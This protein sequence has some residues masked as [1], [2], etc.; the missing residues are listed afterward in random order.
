MP[1][2]RRLIPILPDRPYSHPISSQITRSY[3]V[4]RDNFSRAYLG[5]V[6][7]LTIS[8]ADPVPDNLQAI[9]MTTINLNGDTALAD[10]PFVRENE[11]TLTCDI[12]PERPGFH[13]YRAQFSLDGGATWFR[14]TVEDAW[15]LVDPP[16]A[17]GLRLYVLVPTVS[18]TMADWKSD[19][20]RI[21]AMGFNAVH[22]LPITTLDTSESPYAARDLFDI[23]L[24]YLRHG[25]GQDG[26]S[27]LEDF[28]E[29]ARALD[30]RLCFD[31]VL[32]HI[33]V[34]STMARRAPDWIVPDKDQPDGLHRAGYESEK[35]WLPWNDLVQINYKH[36]SEMVRS[37]IWTYMIE[38]A[39]FWAKYANDTG[40]FVRFDNLHSSDPDF[41]QALTVAL[42]AEYPGVGLLAEYF[43]NEATLL[44]TVPR[45]GLNLVLA[46]P[47][48]YKFASGVR[49]YLN[50]IH[51]HTRQVRYFMPATSHD[52]GTPAQEFGTVDSTIPRYVAAALMGTGSTGIAQGV[53][54]GEEERINF[55]GRKPKI[56]YPTEAMFASFISHVNALLVE[57]PA[58]RSGENF[59]F[60]DNGH[61]AVLAAYRNDSGKESF[62]FLIVC[63]FDTQ[64]PQHI[65]V[66]LTPFLET[67]GPFPC[68]ELLGGKSQTFPRPHLDLMLPP[69]GAQ[70]LRFLTHSAA[71]L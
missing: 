6:I 57:F 56:Q 9:L 25:T 39:L 42:H 53:E 32:N 62:G 54:Y 64:S 45:W 36:P 27:Q 51:G 66:D 3:P 61:P 29:E 23:D 44:H 12:K 50:Y 1:T 49:D 52:S 35:G 31:L 18:G 37:E 5:K 17:D 58:F 13:S 16:Q 28:I 47:W 60:V 34:H 63:N 26:L 59:Q 41:V 65:A 8:A 67:D 70:V 46:T 22:L 38:Y 14:D 15:L 71:N 4:G 10:I 48:D 43:T 33:G 68:V 19:L 21:R 7:T 2:N 11:R 40:G 69:C 20:K 24:S 30:L 55:I